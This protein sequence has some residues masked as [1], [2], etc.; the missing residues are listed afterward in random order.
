MARAYPHANDVKH[1]DAFVN[2]KSTLV[3][4]GVEKQAQHGM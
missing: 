2:D 1:E 3:G 4:L